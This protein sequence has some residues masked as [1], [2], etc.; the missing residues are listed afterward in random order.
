MCVF[1]YYPADPRPRREAE[2]LQKEGIP[3]DIL[4][5]RNK[6][7]PRR[8]CI[9]G[10]EVYRLPLRRSRGGMIRYCFEYLF[11]I[12]MASIVLSVLTVRKQYH[13]VHIHNMPDILIISALLPKLLGAKVILD[14]HDPMPEVFMAKYS[15]HENHMVVRLLRAM[16][17]FSIWLSD[18]VLTPNA[19]FRDLFVARG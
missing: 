8:E 15:L 13:L 9:E 10:V 5:L 11:F 2:A 4:C 19:A 18:L 1:S 6:S 7:Q 3:V 14:L 16:E 17:H 12:C